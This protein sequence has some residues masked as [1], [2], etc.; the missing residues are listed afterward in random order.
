MYAKI[1][2]THIVYQLYVTMYKQFFDQYCFIEF[3]G[4]L[5]TPRS[6]YRIP[7]LSGVVILMRR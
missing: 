7:G 1:V 3:S 2:V 6:Y 5:T 4:A